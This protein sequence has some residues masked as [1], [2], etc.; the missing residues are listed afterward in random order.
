MRCSDGTGL[1]NHQ[2]PAF[3]M[4][5]ISTIHK[6][7]GWISVRIAA[8]WFPLGKLHEGL[9]V[10]VPG[11]TTSALFYPL[12]VVWLIPFLTVPSVLRSLFCCTWE[13]QRRG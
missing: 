6:R 3:A 10:S 1:F 7:F 8:S 9:G 12:R 4:R 13:S 2:I 5:F 11:E